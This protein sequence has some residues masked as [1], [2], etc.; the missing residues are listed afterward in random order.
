VKQNLS[1][2]LRQSLSPVQLEFIQLVAA[3][4]SA[5]G[6]PLYMVGG[7]V[8]DLLLGRANLDIDLVVEGEAPT[9]ARALVGKYEGKATVHSRFG[10][11]KWD[12]RESRI[13]KGKF[14]ADN[15][16]RSGLPNFLDLV[17]ARSETYKHP[18]SLP[19]VKMGKIEDDL[20]RR[21]FTI[22]TLAIRLDSSY[23]GDLR[24]DYGGDEDL[25]HGSIRVL[26]DRSFIDDPTRIYRAIRYEQ[27]FGFK[28]VDETL[29]LIPEASALMVKLSPQR[30]RHE[31]DLILEEPNKALI[32][33]RLADLNLLKIIH[34]ALPWDESVQIR[35]QAKRRPGLIKG[36]DDNRLTAWLLWLLALSDRQFESLN[37]RL[38]FTAPLL[39]TLL[40]ASKLFYDL[41]LFG[42]RK[43]SECVE[44]LDEVPLHAVYAA[45]LGAPEGRFKLALE[46]YLSEWRHVKP[47]TTGNDLK[48]RGLPPGPKYQKILKELRNAWLDQ[49]VQDIEAEKR[50]LE[51]TLRRL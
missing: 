11:A 18:A 12:I 5:L 14:A 16:P 28:V 35:F 19:T 9:L 20:Q 45:Y 8:R 30:I 24:N 46:K 13:W 25:R 15:S 38:H 23:F 37:K 1:G 47:K 10:T 2:L 4:A 44:Y 41:A 49:E 32:L 51:E 27:R 29:A 34:A 6:Y 17:S 50:R 3:E 26:H 40:A 42:D 22:N 39:K 48:R 31:L 36:R 7:I 33:A 21:D 43:P